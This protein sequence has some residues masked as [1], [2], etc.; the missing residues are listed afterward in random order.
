MRRVLNSRRKQLAKPRKKTELQN[1]LQWFV[2]LR[3]HIRLI[4]L[5]CSFSLRN[6]LSFILE[7]CH[8][9]HVTNLWLLRTWLLNSALKKETSASFEEERQLWPSILCGYFL[10][11]FSFLIHF[12]FFDLG[13]EGFLDLLKSHITNSLITPI[14]KSL[15]LVS[16]F[17]KLYER[18]QSLM[19]FLHIG[20]P[21]SQWEKR[22]PLDPGAFNIMCMP[23]MSLHS[24]PR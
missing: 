19:L 12:F 11:P 7:V 10:L 14:W 23:W 9:D 21:M 3:V 6:S 13:G 20:T 8:R 17:P 5:D 16:T 24:G 15:W 22:L 4:L 2:V 1:Q 18:Q